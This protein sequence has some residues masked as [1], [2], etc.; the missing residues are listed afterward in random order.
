MSCVTCKF[1]TAGF[2]TTNRGPGEEESVSTH[3]ST[4]VLRHL[5]R[6]LQRWRS[7]PPRYALRTFRLSYVRRAH[8]ARPALP[9]LQSA[10]HRRKS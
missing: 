9:E 8:D 2:S 7:M 10:I 3:G 6:K 4:Y 5:R 1:T